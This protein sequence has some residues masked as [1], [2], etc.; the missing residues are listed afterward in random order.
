VTITQ[1]A[2]LTGIPASTISTWA[3]RGQVL[4]RRDPTATNPRRGGRLV[5]V[6]AVRERAAT[7]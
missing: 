6:T 7:S 5:D 1:A 2:A 3:S 4:T